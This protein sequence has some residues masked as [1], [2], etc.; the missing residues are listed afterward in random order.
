[1]KNFL[2]GTHMA[3]SSNRKLKKII[4]YTLIALV[5]LVVAGNLIYPHC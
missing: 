2:K 1:M 5:I 4:A 3:K